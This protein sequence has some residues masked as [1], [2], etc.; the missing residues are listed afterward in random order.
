M[1]VDKKLGLCFG[2]STQEARKPRWVLRNM[3]LPLK[4]TTFLSF[5]GNMGYMSV[6]DENF[7]R[8]LGVLRGKFYMFAYGGV[9]G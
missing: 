6:K 4:N 5:L 9:G 3:F 1:A 8:L 2:Q 7:P